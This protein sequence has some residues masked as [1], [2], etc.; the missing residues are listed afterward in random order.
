MLEQLNKL[1]RFD[2]DISEDDVGI[3]K[4]YKY[5]GSDYTWLDNKMNKF[6]FAA[7]DYLPKV[8]ESL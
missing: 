1:I 5:H 3:L 8:S 7:V 6:W 2:K 4:N